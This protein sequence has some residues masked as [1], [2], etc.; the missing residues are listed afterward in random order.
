MLTNFSTLWSDIPKRDI[1]IDS[2][3]DWDEKQFI[4]NRAA[5]DKEDTRIAR[6]ARF[7]FASVRLCCERILE[8]LEGFEFSAH[9]TYT[10]TRSRCFAC[11]KICALVRVGCSGKYC[12]LV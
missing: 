5:S 4:K 2:T 12:G 10:F 7:E 9:N 11:G 6:V 3:F 8:N 1:H